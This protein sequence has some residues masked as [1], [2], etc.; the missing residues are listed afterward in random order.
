MKKHKGTPVKYNERERY[1][2]DGL[3]ECCVTVLTYTSK[4]DRHCVVVDGRNKLIYDPA[5][6]QALEL[7]KDNLSRCVDQGCDFCP[8][9]ILYSIINCQLITT[10]ASV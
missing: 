10:S 3:D 4:S 6:K 1:I 5:E 2:L 7:T 9:Y 8:T